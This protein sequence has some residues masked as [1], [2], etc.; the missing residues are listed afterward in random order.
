M[1]SSE[2]RGHVNIRRKCD[3][4]LHHCKIEPWMTRV[5]K[6]RRKCDTRTFVG[7]EMVPEMTFG[8][9]NVCRDPDNITSELRRKGR[10]KMTQSY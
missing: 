3:D 6:K 2:V 7:S 10:R 4:N 9:A 8:G 5:H 1:L